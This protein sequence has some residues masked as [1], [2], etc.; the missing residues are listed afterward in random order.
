MT[1]DADAWRSLSDV[2]GDIVRKV[3][4]TVTVEAPRSGAHLEEPKQV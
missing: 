1:V 2:V 4:P 3:S